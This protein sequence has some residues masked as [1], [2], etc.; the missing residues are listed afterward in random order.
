MKAGPRPPCVSPLCS[1]PSGLFSLEG[2]HGPQ[3]HPR[4]S[5]APSWEDFCSRRDVGTPTAGRLRPR[6]R[7]K[8][9]P[10]PGCYT[11]PPGRGPCQSPRGSSSRPRS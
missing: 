3:G 5:T 8:Q 4:A 7:E 1:F 6:V 2:S 10:R 11:P 9:T